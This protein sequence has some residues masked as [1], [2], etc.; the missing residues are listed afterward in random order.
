MIKLF[1]IEGDSLYPFFKNGQRVLCIKTFKL[2]K[3]NVGDFV[4]FYKKEYGLMVKKIKYIYQDNVYLEGTTPMSI[5]SRNF[6]T[7]SL[8]EIKYKLFSSLKF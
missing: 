8:S 6:G 3:L 1:K 2:V 5:D 7:V 4:V